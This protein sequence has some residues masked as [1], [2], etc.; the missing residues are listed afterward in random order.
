MNIRSFSIAVVIPSLIL[1]NGCAHYRAK[2]LKP[3]MPTTQSVEQS[4][5]FSYEVF[6]VDDCVR[7]LDRNVIAKGYQPIQ[8][9]LANNTDH[10]FSVSTK[11]FSFDC[12]KPQEVAEKFHTNTVGRAIGY[13]V[14]GLFVWPFIIPA[15]V[16]GVGSSRSNKRLDADFSRKTFRSQVIK[17]HTT[18]NGLLFVS[19][20]DFDE[21][22]T[23]TVTDQ[24]NNQYIVLSPAKPKYNI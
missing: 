13:G 19:C 9:T 23:L 21:N 24:A 16:D 11:T 4:I 5:S 10:Y 17:P 14:A 2:P 1:L 22:F 12:L 6:D 8:I 15:I 20:D 18:V 3:L 7:Y